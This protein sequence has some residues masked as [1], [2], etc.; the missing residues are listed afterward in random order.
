[1]RNM[2]ETQASKDKL[3]TQT[4]LQIRNLQE[5]IDAQII[6]LDELKGARMTEE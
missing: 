2:S 4:S 3:D 1:M 6:Q 5:T